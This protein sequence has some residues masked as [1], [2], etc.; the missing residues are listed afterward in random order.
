MS[1]RAGAALAPVD[2]SS[3][4]PDGTAER[5]LVAAE[6][7]LARLGV[8]RLSMTD[9][10]IQAGLSRGAVY[11]HFSDRRT[12]LDAVL[13]R[14]AN[15]FVASSAES[16]GRRRTLVAQVAEAAVFIREHM[17][18]RVLTLRLP[19]DA[20]SVLATMLTSRLE[21]LVEEWV[22]FW[23]PYLADAEARGEIRSGVDHRQA[24]EWI[25]RMMLSFAIMPA[26]S[27]DADHPEQVRAF[28]RA[29]IVD[30]LGPAATP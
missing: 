17:G 23:L 25:V 10:A 14:A 15:R 4:G 12:L 8:A 11:L 13:T 27:F 16:V 26:V 5:I 19:A 30:G 9:V 24:A 18:D 1:S 22:E 6:Q 28:V 20:E 2:G 7:C 3:P 21:H 29:F